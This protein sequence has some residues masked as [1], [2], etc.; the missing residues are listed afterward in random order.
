MLRPD[1]P[2]CLGALQGP[3]KIGKGREE[4]GDPRPSLGAIND[5]AVD[6]EVLAEKS[7]SGFEIPPVECVV[8]E[9]AHKGFIFVRCHDRVSQVFC[10]G[11][12]VRSCGDGN[13]TRFSVI[14][15]RLPSTISVSARSGSGGASGLGRPVRDGGLPPAQRVRRLRGLPDRNQMPPPPRCRDGHVLSAAAAP[16]RNLKC[17]PWLPTV[18]A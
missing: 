17:V 1:G 13:Y 6:R 15:A 3:M 11:W 10:Q 4:R 8:V 7:V 9:P 14:P 16:V 12:P 5:H 18:W 2:V